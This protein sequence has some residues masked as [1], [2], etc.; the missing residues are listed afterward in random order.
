MLSWRL[1]QKHPQPSFLLRCCATEVVPAHRVIRMLFDVL[2][3]HPDKLLHISPPIKGSRPADALRC[4]MLFFG[5]VRRS[6]HSRTT[7]GRGRLITC[8]CD[9]ALLFLELLTAKPSRCTRS[10]RDHLGEVQPSLVNHLPVVQS[11]LWRML[12]NLKTLLQTH[13]ML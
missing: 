10:S 8:S 12:M 4:R 2:L 3:T 7:G 6:R 9:V 13:F 5:S 11:S 1:E